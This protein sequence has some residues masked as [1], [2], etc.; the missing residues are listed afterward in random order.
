MAGPEQKEPAPSKLLGFLGDFERLIGLYGATVKGLVP[1]SDSAAIIDSLSAVAKSEARSLAKFVGDSYGQSSP[2]LRGEVDA[3][4]ER[5]AGEEL[6]QGGL[7]VAPKATSVQALI[8]ISEIIKLIKKIIMFILGLLFPKGIPQWIIKLL[9]IIDE[10]IHAILGQ[11]SQR[12]QHDASE[13]HM[14]FLQTMRMLRQL[15]LL[16]NGGSQE[17]T[18][19]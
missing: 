7:A 18:S 17:E 5:L 14:D 15:E 13:N 3:F 4:F 6:M 1:E 8:G 16:E 19:A 2:A 10:I 12:A 9:D 11:R